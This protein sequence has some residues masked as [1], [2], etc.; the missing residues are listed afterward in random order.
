[1]NHSVILVTWWYMQ[2]SES[3]AL[4]TSHVLRTMPIMSFKVSEKHIQSREDPKTNDDY[5]NCPWHES[6]CSCTMER[7]RQLVLRSL[8]SARAGAEDDDVYCGRFSKWCS[9]KHTSSLPPPRKFLPEQAASNFHR[10]CSLPAL[11][12]SQDLGATAAKSS[13]HDCHAKVNFDCDRWPEYF[14]C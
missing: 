1:M 12:C 2:I 10:V 4:V 6:V 5:F 11:S 7:P 14:R 8:P 9:I 3:P 13:I